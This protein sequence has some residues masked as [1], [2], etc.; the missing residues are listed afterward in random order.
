[1]IRSN[2]VLSSEPF[3]SVRRR[4]SLLTLSLILAAAVMAA[5]APATAL[6]LEP[7]DIWQSVGVSINDL[8]SGKTPTLVIIAQARPGLTPPLEAAIAIPKGSELAWAGEVLGG[9][10]NDDPMLQFTIEK[11][12]A[13]DLV[14][15]TLVNSPRVQLE[16]TV[17]PEMLVRTE[18]QA[19]I[20]LK[21]TSAGPLDAAALQVYVP[22]D[23]H[24]EGGTP[25]PEVHATPGQYVVYSVETS[26][27][28][29][30]QMLTL[31]GTVVSGVAPEMGE[32][33]DE[34]DEDV[35]A[36]P[37]E[38]SPTSDVAETG[39]FDIRWLLGIAAVL[40]VAVAAYLVF[41][42]VKT[43]HT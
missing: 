7:T 42:F 11:G 25:A 2:A 16:L 26:P 14:K 21:Y 34:P 31:A 41:K 8:G 35:V 32:V 22:A 13:Y 33:A 17:P 5:F 19:T 38:Q 18:A 3:A 27:V 12:D 37:D 24:L 1:M 4:I 9:D 10:P 29:A 23:A 43:S 15:F 20:D 36:T 39:G 40:L 30:G 28:V 6:A